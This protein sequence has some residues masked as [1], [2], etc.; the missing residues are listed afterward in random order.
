MTRRRLR[1]MVSVIGLWGLVTFTGACNQATFCQVLAGLGI[2][3]DNLNNND[4]NT[5]DNNA[6]DNNIN[7]NNVNDNNVNDNG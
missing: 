5:N 4:N 2:D 3:C 7:D 1:S 6:N